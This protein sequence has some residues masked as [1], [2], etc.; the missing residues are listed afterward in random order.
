MILNANNYSLRILIRYAFLHSQ[1]HCVGYCDVCPNENG[2]YTVDWFEQGCG[3]GNLVPGQKEYY[4]SSIVTKAVHLF[5]HPFDNLVARK[6]LGVENRMEKN[7]EKWSSFDIV[8]NSKEGFFDWC[9][10]IDSAFKENRTGLYLLNGEERELF[11]GVPCASELWRYTQWHNLAIAMTN[12]LE[13]PVHYMYYEDYGSDFNATVQGIAH[14]L[15]LKLKRPPEIFVGG[16]SYSDYFD[17]DVAS[18]MAQFVRKFAS[19]ECW[20]HLSRYLGKWEKDNTEVA[21]VPDVSSGRPEIAWLLSF[22]NSGTTY[23][24]ENVERITNTST[25][26]NYPGEVDVRVRARPDI[27]KGPF[28][29]NVSLGVPT[30]TWLT[31]SHCT[32]Y[33][34]DC[35]WKTSFSTLETF[36]ARCGAD[37]PQG[38]VDVR[39]SS[40][41][42]SKVVHLFRDPFDN[43]VARM[44]HGLM[45][46]KKFLGWSD[47]RLAPFN[48]T[49]QGLLSWCAY[50]DENFWGDHAQRTVPDQV[51]HTVLALVKD[52]PC[53]SDFYRYG[54]W[55]SNAINL[56][57]KLKVPTHLL[58]YEDYAS[59]YN[60]TVSDLFGFLGLPMVNEPAPFILGKTYGDFFTM[61]DRL[62]VQR[63]I[64]NVSSPECWH[65]LRSRYF[66]GGNADQDELE[67][68]SATVS[69]GRNL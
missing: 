1:T 25:A 62:A 14:F 41:E 52:V 58:Y 16:L 38:G 12:R 67:A 29:H 19:V 48:D 17:D 21:A 7:P 24:V 8:H 63:F 54:Q 32:G 50:V 43:I 68:T 2:V 28:V 65:L 20:H 53:H 55:H 61:S 46:R 59:R 69:R 45:R 31:K 44:H 51:S 39:Y 40:S 4:S 5:R 11:A 35:D 47:D 18:V 33:C 30:T 27:E 26:V 15:G 64:Q 10:Y 37:R 13:V 9:R 23:T 49:R 22:P 36:E 42:V 34:D 56:S 3:L 6:H 57:Q 60:E 66:S